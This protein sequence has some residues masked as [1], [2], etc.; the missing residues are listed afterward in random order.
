M[1]RVDGWD[2]LKKESKK[3]R[4]ERQTYRQD[5]RSAKE[6]W[7]GMTIELK[8]LELG[9]KAFHSILPLRKVKIIS[10]EN[11]KYYNLIIEL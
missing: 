9:R 10:F 6:R 4:T 1:S 3:E 7:D 11:C 2:V 5:S 8:R